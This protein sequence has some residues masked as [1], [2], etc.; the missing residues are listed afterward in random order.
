MPF[1]HSFLIFILIIFFCISP[2]CAS[3]NT[4]GSDTDGKGWIKTDTYRVINFAILAGALFL[5]LRKPVKTVLEN[6]ITD[7]RQHF[8]DLEAKKA[9]AEN[10]LV[11]YTDKIKD[12]AAETEKVAAQYV[13]QGEEA[14]SRIIDA[15]QQGA[16]RLEA[17]ARKNIENEFKA[18]RQSLQQ[19]IIDKAMG[20]AQTLIMA[21]IKDEDQKRLIDE[22]LDKVV[23][24]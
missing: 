14:R 24:A 5:L 20:K 4:H 13:K 12:L 8:K 3:D 23:T 11:R 16:V 22:Y 6:R 19:E 17:H 7:I 2:V 9:D 1:K 15:A 21:D 10:E 18:A